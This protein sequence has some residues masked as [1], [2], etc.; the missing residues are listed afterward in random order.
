MFL[1]A[2]KDCFRVLLEA[3]LGVPRIVGTVSPSH[4]LALTTDASVTSNEVFRANG[5]FRHLLPI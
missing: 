4:A 5:S 2:P 3:G 1:A